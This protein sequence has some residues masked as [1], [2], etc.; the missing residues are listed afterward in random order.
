MTEL[1]VRFA[2]GATE[3][4]ARSLALSLGATV[5]R[6]MRS[7]PG[8]VLLLLKMDPKTVADVEARLTAHPKVAAVEPNHGGFQ[9]LD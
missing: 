6:R 3:D 8:E 7:D 2:P 5:R 4:E 9:A 1:I